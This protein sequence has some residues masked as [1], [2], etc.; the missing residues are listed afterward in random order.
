MFNER[1]A[2]ADARAYR[3]RGLD[4]QAR[5]IVRFASERGLAG[6]TLLEVGG[7]V[8]ALALELVAAG[9][10]RAENVE[11]SPY[12]EPAARALAD[13]KGLSDRVTRHVADFVAAER[14]IAPADIVVLHKVVCCYGD[15]PAM[16][17]AAARHARRSLLLTFPAGRWWIRAGLR[18]ASAV[19]RVFRA[20]FR[21]HFHEPSAIRREAEL[22][23]LGVAAS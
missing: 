6:T 13:E 20:R 11:A 10:T 1:R 19:Q 12:Y 5:R 21:V 18:T 8:G 16:V 2:E 17:G 14:S 15:M 4:P 9:V 7:G 22:A 23:G 3:R